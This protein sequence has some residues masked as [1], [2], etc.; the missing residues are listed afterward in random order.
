MLGSFGSLTSGR[1]SSSANRSQTIGTILCWKADI[2]ASA[3]ATLWFVCVSVFFSRSS[4]VWNWGFSGIVGVH[5][6]GRLRH[7]LNHCFIC[8]YFLYFIL[9]LFFALIC[10]N[11]YIIKL[12]NFILSVFNI[13][14][15]II[16]CFTFFQ[17]HSIPWNS[18][19]LSSLTIGCFIYLSKILRPWL[20]GV[21]LALRLPG[22]RAWPIIGN[23]LL[24][25]DTNGNFRITI[26]PFKE[27][28]TS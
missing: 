19:I 2:H 25:I 17:L 10:F 11:S 12:K 27:H 1:F 16:I 6:Q 13:K 28:V 21:Y 4:P 22:P 26:G 14:T 23:C 3:T 15:P 9:W 18:V 5:I 7:A 24:A 8:L 20:R